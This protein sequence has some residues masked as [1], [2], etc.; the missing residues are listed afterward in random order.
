MLDKCLSTSPLK[1]R[2]EK[3]SWLQCQKEEW[4]GKGERDGVQGWLG[5]FQ[6]KG[7]GLELGCSGLGFQV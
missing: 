3:H 1:N 4:A 6:G 5:L 2:G 7:Q